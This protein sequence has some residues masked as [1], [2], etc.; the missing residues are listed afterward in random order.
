MAAVWSQLALAT[1]SAPAVLLVVLVVLGAYIRFRR[2]VKYRYPPGPT[3]LPFIGNVHQ[4]PMDYQWRKMAEWGRRHGMELLCF[5]AAIG[6]HSEH[7][8]QGMSC[9]RSSSAPRPSY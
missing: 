3:A 9:S 7:I 8:T 2:S 4:L 5:P 1:S 6:T